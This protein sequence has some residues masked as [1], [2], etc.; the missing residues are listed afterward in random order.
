MNETADLTIVA[1]IGGFALVALAA[2][3]LLVW[4]IV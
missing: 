4:G 3:G 2:I 1:F